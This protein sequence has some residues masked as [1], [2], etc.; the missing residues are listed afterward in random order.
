MYILYTKKRKEKKRKNG[1]RKVILRLVEEDT[2]TRLRQ[3]RNPVVYLDMQE[4]EFYSQVAAYNHLLLSV[5]HLQSM[6]S[7]SYNLQ[8]TE[9]FMHPRHSAQGSCYGFNHNNTI[10]PCCEINR[11]NYLVYNQGYSAVVAD[12]IRS[13]NKCISSCRCCDLR[14]SPSGRAGNYRDWFSLGCCERV[15]VKG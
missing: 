6:L 8:H 4:D 1:K 10:S 15:S 2:E 12:E 11:F 7:C 5:S 3:Q 14:V 13:K 9:L